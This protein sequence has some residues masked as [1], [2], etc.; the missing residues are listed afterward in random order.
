MQIM[1]DAPAIAEDLDFKDDSEI[2]ELLNGPD[3]ERAYIS[4][5]GG[6]STMQM[7]SCMW[8]GMSTLP[9]FARRAGIRLC[10][11]FESEMKLLNDC[12]FAS[13]STR[14]A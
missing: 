10:P 8:S 14:T 11:L 12:E 5:I 2:L 4:L 1:D 13:S 7:A 3:P 9:E 6:Q